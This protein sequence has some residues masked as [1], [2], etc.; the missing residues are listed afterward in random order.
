MKMRSSTFVLGA[1]AALFAGSVFAADMT[2]LGSWKTIDDKT[3]KVKSIVE[4]SNT[5]G[6]LVGKVAQVLNSEKGPNPTCDACSGDR[7][8]KPITGMT[9]MWDVVQD[10]DVWDGG[11]I[12]DPN[13]GKTYGVKLTPIENGTKLQVRGFMGFSWLG[14]TQVWERVTP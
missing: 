5:G 10:G 6:K 3:G 13:N 8:D 4:I 12:L 9:I 7:K 14:R 11:S 1:I 2:P